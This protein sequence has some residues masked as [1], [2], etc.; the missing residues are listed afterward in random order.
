MGA[1]LILKR[2][3]GPGSSGDF[4]RHLKFLR[5]SSAFRLREL[6]ARWPENSEAG[7]LHLRRAFE[8]SS[9]EVPHRIFSAAGWPIPPARIPKADI[10]NGC[11]GRTR[12]VDGTIRSLLLTSR[13][14]SLLP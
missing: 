14:R 8:W 7:F 9:S 10:G 11:L 1:W 12:P 13:G 2:L 4:G 6:D 3:G 5:S